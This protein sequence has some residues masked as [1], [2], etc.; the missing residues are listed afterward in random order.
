MKFFFAVIVIALLFG[1]IVGGA[2]LWDGSYY[3]YKALDTAEPYAPH[4]RLINVP[5]QWPVIWAS[6]IIQDVNTLKIMF[7][8]MYA[9]VPLGSLLLAWWIVKDSHPTLFVWAALGVGFGTLMLQLTFVAEAILVLHMFWPLLLGLLVVPRRSVNIIIA[10]LSVLILF[11]HPFAILLLSFAAA[12]AFVMGWRYPERRPQLW[13][14][15]AA[16][17]AGIV[18]VVLR[19]VTMRDTYESER[20][21]LETLQAS[22][23]TSLTGV[24]FVGMFAIYAATALI[25]LV[26]LILHARRRFA[27]RW[28][29]QPRTLAQIM[30]GLEFASVLLAG[31]ALLIWGGYP[32]LWQTALTFRTWAL[33]VSLPFMVLAVVEALIQNSAW[34]TDLEGMW[35]HRRRTVQMI[36]MVFLIVLVAQ[37]LSWVKLD[38]SVREAVAAAPGPCVPQ[39]SIARQSASLLGHWSMT[40]YSILQQGAQPKKIVLRDELCQSHAF[41]STLPIADWDQRSW[42]GGWF[43]MR[44]LNE[45]LNVQ[46]SSAR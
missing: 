1:I 44:L 40:P 24:R 41:A 11:S 9:L 42:E 36:G 33:F 7:G 30:Y 6:R 13:V 25:F 17:G 8:L 12:T 3:L 10:V 15:T 35:R 43:D 20:L 18:V 34:R 22:F 37:S 46:Q 39:S 14:W 28:D 32:R 29:I 26:P 5:L 19:F 16:F 27:E 23:Y 45:G 4:G 31:S 38:N 21:S 2:M